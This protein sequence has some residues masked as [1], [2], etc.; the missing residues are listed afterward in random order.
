MSYKVTLLSQEEMSELQPSTDSQKFIMA[1]ADIHGICVAL[2]A[3][4]RKMVDMWESN[5]HAMSDTVWPHATIIL[6]NDPSYETEVFYD[7]VGH[8]AI[9]YNF[10]YYGWVKSIALAVASD[11]LED[12]YQGLSHVHGAAID[13]PFGGV[14]LIAPSKTG[15]T[16]HSWGLL[17]MKGARLITDDWYFAKV[18]GGYPLVYGSEKNCYID[19]DIGKVWHE[20]QPL[21]DSS[22]FDA[23][24]RAVA[25]IRW[26]TGSKSVIPMTTIRHIILL[27]R[28]AEDPDLTVELSAEELYHT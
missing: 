8:T 25:D 12:G 27:K 19:A 21:V 28:D 5:F 3:A 18:G 11:I 20:F 2:Y 9:L 22:E 13:T 15:K 7:N 17:R 26:V 23:K 14:T 4:D 1:K 6:L 24:G 16:T 10:D